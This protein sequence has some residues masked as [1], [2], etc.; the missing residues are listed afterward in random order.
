MAFQEGLVAKRTKQLIQPK[1]FFLH[2]AS[3]IGLHREGCIADCTNEP[4]FQALFSYHKVLDT[5]NNK[6]WC[7]VLLFSGKTHKSMEGAATHRLH[8]TSPPLPWRA[9]FLAIPKCFS[10][11]CLVQLPMCRITLLHTVH[12]Y[13]VSVLKIKSWTPEIDT[14]Q[15]LTQPKPKVSFTPIFNWKESTKYFL[16]AFISQ[17]C[18]ESII[19]Q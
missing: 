14:Y 8:Y 9:W 13:P 2:M 11:T 12:K 6:R 18:W 1:V 4:T 19:T 16:V 10:F 15:G 7:W 3:T 5:W 17:L